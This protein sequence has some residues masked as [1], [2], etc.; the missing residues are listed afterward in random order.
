MT[1][2]KLRQG[3]QGAPTAEPRRVSV[4]V[5]TRVDFA[6]GW[7]DVP[8][9]ASSEGGI[10]LNAAIDRYVEGCAEWTG[11]GLRLSYNL[12]LPPDAHL[13]T[14]SASNLAWLELIHGL[15]ERRV[16]TTERAELAF[17]L[18]ELLGEK[19]GKQDQYA[20]AL[21]G[22][23]LLRFGAAD[24]P[25]QIE[26]LKLSDDHVA[27]LQRRCILCHAGPSAGSS[28]LHKQVWKRFREGDGE[29][30]R[31]LRAIRDTALLARDALLACDWSGLAGIL[32]RNR[33]LA[34]ALGGGAL[35]NRMD[36]LFE[37]GAQAGAL[38]SKG[39]GAGGGGML[40]FLCEDERKDAVQESLKAAGGKIIPFD[41]APRR[42]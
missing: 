3:E 22:L 27:A 9:Y 37:A 32:T 10:V 14:S 13:G 29:T 11:D 24:E 8:D 28:S 25:A 4:R 21:G 19:G 34:R 33:E 41:F 42:D 40:L 17:R 23:N 30:R 12:D 31:T 20:A 18:E 35:T 39:C 26:P 5:P 38:G 2:R 36:R 15:I 7:S 1:E 16:S 6:G